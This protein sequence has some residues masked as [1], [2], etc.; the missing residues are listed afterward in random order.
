[1]AWNKP[2]DSWWVKGAN[3]KNP[4]HKDYK[5]AAEYKPTLNAQD[6]MLHMSYDQSLNAQDYDITWGVGPFEPTGVYKTPKYPPFITTKVYPKVTT[7]VNNSYEDMLLKEFQ[8]F[9][10]QPPP[11]D[12]NK[13]DPKPEKPE[14]PPKWHISARWVYK[15]RRYQKYM[16]A[17]E[18]W[19][20]RKKLLQGPSDY[21]FSSS[22]PITMN[23]IQEAYKILS[24]NKSYPIG[25][26]KGTNY[27]NSTIPPQY[28]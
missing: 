14:L 4:K 22:G 13:Y 25:T 16:Q 20:A 3:E 7:K 1:M 9:N 27:W 12:Y 8:N 28:P 18:A 21:N 23:E 24:S 6:S 5:P 10:T 15:K 11:E 2:F 17:L 26:Y 19:K